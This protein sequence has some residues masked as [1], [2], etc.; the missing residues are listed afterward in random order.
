M[1]EEKPPIAWDEPENKRQLTLRELLRPSLITM[2]ICGCYTY[3][4]WR[5]RSGQSKDEGWLY[6]VLG[7]LYRIFCLIVCLIAFGKAL[8]AFSNVPSD[9]LLMN[10]VK[11]IWYS[12]CFIIFLISLKSSFTKRG[13]QKVAFDFWDE[14]IGPEMTDLGIKLPVDQIRKRQMIHIA[15]AIFLATFNV[16]CNIL[17]FADAISDRFKVFVAAPF[18]PSIPVLIIDGLILTFITMLWFL[19]VSYMM[20]VSTVIASTFDVYNNYLEE[21]IS[22]NCTTVIMLCQRLRTLHLNIDKVVSLFDRDFGCYLATNF[23]FT[24]GLSCFMLYQLLQH[25]TDTV[26]T[27]L[28]A[29][30][31]AM[32]LVLLGLTSITA[33][34][35]NNTVGND[36]VLPPNLVYRTVIWFRL[37]RS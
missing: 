14:K 13:S 16:V 7:T 23:A 19:P 5:I 18:T 34:I 24:I 22:P 2:A 20:T 21:K 1:E 3:D 8:A 6:R 4:P 35:V 12:Q 10:I 29:F 33:A 30:W 9:F 26:S 25:P 28:F 11:T 17:M 37:N 27:V 31:V 36:L 32:P 15:V